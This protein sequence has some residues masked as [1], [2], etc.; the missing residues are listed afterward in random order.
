MNQARID[1]ALAAAL[2]SRRAFSTLRRAVTSDLVVPDPWQL[3]LMRFTAEHVDKYDDLPREKD[4]EL[5]VAQE[6]EARQ[7]ALRTAW[8][9]LRR[10]DLSGF[11]ED[12]L[13]DTMAKAF[14][15]QAALTA[16]TRL[17]SAAE[18]GR[19]DSDQLAEMAAAVSD[20]RPISIDGLAD[21]RDVDLHLHPSVDTSI[22]VESGIEKLD[23]ILGGGFTSELVFLLAG[24]GVGKTTFLV[25]RLLAAALRGHRCLHVTYE[26][27]TD[28]TLHRYYR[29][30]ANANRGEFHTDYDAVRGRVG[31]WL[32]LAEGSVHVLYQP[33][34]T[35]TVADLRATCE[36]FADIHG[37]LDVLAVDYL[38]LLSRDGPQ[39]RGLRTDEQLGIM[40]HELRTICTTMD[41]EVITASQANREGL[42][43]DQL[44]LKHMAGAISKAQ[45]ADVVMG[46]VQSAE[47]AQMNQARL[48]LLKMRDYPGQFEI[49]LF[50][51]KD[52]MTILDLD[53]PTARARRQRI[54][55][56]GAWV[57]NDE[58]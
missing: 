43:A 26:L 10:R 44:T 32:R 19:L 5:W 55:E 27:V 17:A 11:T 16:V 4:F 25:N 29:R 14:R 3:D 20:V 12:Y 49:P 46:L 35:N 57:A 9:R 42:T 28:K 56:E 31:N 22:R 45:A 23:Q 2:K 6:P 8:R 37:G 15:E 7:D 51:D 24:T 41:V 1:D 13:A 34:Y 48:G 54:E 50:Y 47:E 38:D 52:T 53:N 18:G 30:V 39:Y 33:A 40:S 21:M 58:D 36:M